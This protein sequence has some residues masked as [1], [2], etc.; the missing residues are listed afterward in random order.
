MHELSSDDSKVQFCRGRGTGE[1]FP[2]R[3]GGNILHHVKG[4]G[5]VREGEC[6]GGGAICPC[7]MSRY[8]C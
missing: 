3:P 7:G 6:P 4:T 8:P 5:I 2:S 1:V